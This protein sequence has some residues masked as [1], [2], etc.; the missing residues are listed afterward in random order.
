MVQAR[1]PYNPQTTK[2]WDELG[3][4]VHIE[5]PEIPWAPEAKGRKVREFV[6]VTPPEATLA[7]QLPKGA[8]IIQSVRLRNR[9]VVTVAFPP[10]AQVTHVAFSA[11]EMATRHLDAV[12]V[13][14]V[15]GPNNRRYWPDLRW[16]A[17]PLKEARYRALDQ[18]GKVIPVIGQWFRKGDRQRLIAVDASR[19]DAVRKLQAAPMFTKFYSFGPVLLDPA[20]PVVTRKDGPAFEVPLAGKGKLT[21]LNIQANTP[22]IP[23]AVWTVDGGPP[24]DFD[25]MRERAF[26]TF[27]EK[28]LLNRA[29]ALRLDWPAKPKDAPSVT[30]RAREVQG[31]LGGMV[32]TAHGLPAKARAEFKIK[33]EIRYLHAQVGY[34]FAPWQVRAQEAPEG[35]RIRASVTSDRPGHFSDT[36]TVVASFLPTPDIRQHDFDIEAL[37]AQGK[38]LQRLG[39][40]GHSTVKGAREAAMY[41]S[42]ECFYYF[43]AKSPREIAQIRLKVRPMHWVELPPLPMHPRG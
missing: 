42:S 43:R 15:F 35:P 38:P 34:A 37:D 30:W 13:K 25:L 9:A 14:P 36:P 33:P 7:T 31:G 17:V 39:A 1:I 2:R 26:N 16:F 20:P 18:D 24:R 41:G 5:H 32:S 12:P 4:P 8:E 40:A 27:S 29:V 22:G 21:I 23:Y 11:T 3:L 6:L 19:A 28:G 10:D